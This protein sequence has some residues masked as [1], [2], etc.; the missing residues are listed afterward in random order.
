MKKKLELTSQRKHS[1]YP[2]FVDR[3][4]AQINYL[5]MS[6]IKS[7]QFKQNKEEEEMFGFKGDEE[8]QPKKPWD[9]N[10]CI[11]EVI[12]DKNF[13]KKF[14]NFDWDDFDNMFDY[15]IHNCSFDISSKWIVK[16][17]LIHSSSNH[18]EILRFQ[19]NLSS[20]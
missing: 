11:I 20:L 18:L 16:Q 4:E 12:E 8:I 13:I 9:P 15:A 2:T 7:M 17:E 1:T 14:T 19:P 10:Q 6:S 3:S 5:M